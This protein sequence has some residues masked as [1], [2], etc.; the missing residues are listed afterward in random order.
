M[1][2]EK[3]LLAAIA[4]RTVTSDKIRIVRLHRDFHDECQQAHNAIRRDYCVAPLSWAKQDT[5]FNWTSRRKMRQCGRE[6][7]S[8]CRPHCTEWGGWPWRGGGLG[9]GLGKVGGWSG[10]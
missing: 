7:A 6:V 9:N 4:L 5:F 10:D 8:R 2:S 3:C 1:L